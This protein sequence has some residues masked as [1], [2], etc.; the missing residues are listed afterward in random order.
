MC[1]QTLLVIFLA[2]TMSFALSIVFP[3]GSVVS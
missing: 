3:S 1:V 2:S